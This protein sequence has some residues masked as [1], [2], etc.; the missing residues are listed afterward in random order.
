LNTNALN[1]LQLSPQV[2]FPLLDGGKVGIFNIT[3]HL[4]LRGH[5]ITMLALDKNAPT[6][7]VPLEQF[8][9]IVT[10]PHLVRNSVGGALANLFSEEPYL[11][12]R[13]HV[14][15]Y[16]RALSALLEQRKFDVVHA[17][18]LHMAKYG[19]YAKLAKN[20]PIVL[21]EHNVESVIMG[22][23]AER[24]KTPLLNPWFAAQNKKIKAYEGK[25]ALA[26]DSCCVITDEDGARLRELAPTA[27]INVI[28]GGVDASY[29]GERT[30]RVPIPL[31]IAMFGSFDW[32]ANR[33]ALE[34][35][36]G[37][38]FPRILARQPGANLYLIGKGIPP[39]VDRLH[40]GHVITRGFV[41]NLK[42]ELQHYGVTV[43]PLR[44]GGGMRLKI[45]ESFAMQI[46]VISTSVGCEGIVCRS[47]EHLLIADSEGEFAQ[48]VLRVLETAELRGHLVRNAYKLASE[49]YRW[50]M[51]AEEFERVYEEVIRRKTGRWIK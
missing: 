19:I 47:G 8:C 11:I 12:S 18:H 24:M 32:I 45:I 48:Q 43:V 42:E 4:A 10:V 5:A 37:S 23:Y 14:E 30:E 29:F 20:M 44:I 41:P 33:D 17:D 6:D 25:Q 36:V 15:A 51:V 26:F 49:R 7:T 50:E 9:D 39:H 38:I 27:H 46:P 31:S 28:P 16:Q 22:R 2:P 34:W 21:R 3:K 13:Y 40:G 35:F 1:I